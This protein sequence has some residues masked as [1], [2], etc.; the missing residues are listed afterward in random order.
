VIARGTGSRYMSRKSQLGLVLAVL[1][2]GAMWFYADHVFVAH[3]VAEAQASGRP[4]GNLSDLYPRWLGTRELLLR[5]R[6]P[7]SA[8]VTREIQTGYYGRPLDPSRPNDPRD[9]Q[10]FVYP[11]YV[12]FLLVP[13]VSWPFAQVQLAFHIGLALLTLAS[14][15]W[16][17]K[18]VQWEVG[19]ANYVTAV[20]LTLG[21]F[22]FVQAYKLQ[23]LTLLVAAWLAAAMICLVR[24]RPIAAGILLAVAT[25]KPQLV[26]PL[27][28]ALLIWTIG[29]WRARQRW[30]W[31]FLATMVTLTVA[32]VG[33]QP[34]WIPRF[35]AALR[36]YHRYTG[37][38]SW[39]GATLPGSL[40]EIV[41]AGLVAVLLAGVWRLRKTPASSPAFAIAIAWVLS[42]TLLLIPM[43]AAY[44]QL[45]LLPGVFCILRSRDYLRRRN[46]LR[47]AVLLL[48]FG[49]AGWPWL[50]AALLSVARSLAPHV[51]LDVFWP[52]PL[53]T[54]L[55]LPLAAAGLLFSLWRDPDPSWAEAQSRPVSP[56]AN[57][58]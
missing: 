13:T 19:L 43:F 1:F 18:V 2:A 55:M 3:Q 11:L 47:H 25:I 46:W 34:D 22:P 40:P 49:A 9:Q 50:T 31:S 41:W 45:L 7:Y 51:V 58:V 15:W 26:A 27:L 6:D 5:G 14:V 24:G 42:L 8:E 56:A 37:G 35:A 23:Q 44:N 36:A 38:S 53:Y 21:S 52:L 29:D 28:L 54:T 4:R 10:A 32:A 57:P 20:M 39:M 16:W 12:V 33:L 17:L 48:F 30:L